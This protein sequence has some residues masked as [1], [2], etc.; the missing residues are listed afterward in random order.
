MRKRRYRVEVG[1]EVRHDRHEV[2][3]TSRGRLGT[4]SYGK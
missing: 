2:D 4:T 1:E 3:Y